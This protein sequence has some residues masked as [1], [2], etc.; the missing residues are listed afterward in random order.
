MD[1]VND[2]GMVSELR[3]TEHNNADEIARGRSGVRRK[4]KAMQGGW[5]QPERPLTFASS[6]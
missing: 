1:H 3:S 6:A 4:A 2:Q 5:W